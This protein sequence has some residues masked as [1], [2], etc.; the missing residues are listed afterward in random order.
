MGRAAVAPF[1][2]PTGAVV[3]EVVR[4]LLLLLGRELLPLPL[5]GSAASANFLNENGLGSSGA[6]AAAALF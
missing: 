5:R 3:L 1:R 2:V 6:A 4:S